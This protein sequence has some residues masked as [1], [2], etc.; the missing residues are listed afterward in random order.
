MANEDYSTDFLA[1]KQPTPQERLNALGELD[2]GKAKE[3]EQL[4][5]TVNLQQEQAG[6]TRPLPVTAEGLEDLADFQPEYETDWR[7]SYPAILASHTKDVVV[8]APLVG[9]IDFV[10]ETF[11]AAKD[12]AGWILPV[13]DYIQGVRNVAATGGAFAGDFVSRFE[14]GMAQSDR[15]SEVTNELMRANADEIKPELVNPM[16]IMEAGFIQFIEGYLPVAKGL[17]TANAASKYARVGKEAVASAIAA[18]FVLDPNDPNL[19][20]LIETSK[21]EGGM[22]DISGPITEFLSTDPRDPEPTNR[23]KN[24]LAEVATG[25]IAEAVF[26]ILKMGKASFAQRQMDKKIADLKP[27]DGPRIEPDKPVEA[28]DLAAQEADMRALGEEGNAM[29]DEVFGAADRPKDTGPDRMDA[30]VDDAIEIERAPLTQDSIREDFQGVINDDLREQLVEIVTPGNYLQT[31]MSL[32]NNSKF[33]L[34]QVETKEELLA[35]LGTIE[36]IM[37]ETMEKSGR[38]KVQTWEQTTQLARAVGMSAEQAHQLFADVAGGGGLAARMFASHQ[39]MVANGKR[40]L[41]LIK[42]AKETSNP[43]DIIEA[44]RAIELQAAI[45]MEVKGSQGEVARAMNAMKMQRSAT[46]ENFENLA[47]AAR[48][49]GVRSQYIDGLLKGG[50]GSLASI[51]AAAD[52]A[53][54]ATVSEMIA[55]VAINGLLTNP[56]THIVNMASNTTMLALTPWERLVASGI[57]KVRRIAGIGQVDTLSARAAGK[58]IKAMI[59]GL[60]DTFKLTYQALKD[61]APITDVRQRVEIAARPRISANSLG[62]DGK[63][64]MS[65]VVDNVVAPTIRVST[66]LLS[67]EDEFFKS[68]LYRGEIASVAY[69][70]ALKHADAKGLTGKARR[71]FVKKRE[72]FLVENPTVKMQRDAIDVARRGTFQEDA[73]S[74]I[75][76]LVEKVINVHPFVKLVVAPFYR[77]PTNVLRQTFIDRVPVLN[78]LM[79]KN[80]DAIKAGGPEGDLALAR[81]T[82]G[83]A[84]LVTGFQL[85]NSFSGPD[86]YIEIIGK[87][88]YESSGRFDKVKDYSIRIGDTWYRYNRF[89]PIGSWLGFASDFHSISESRYDPADPEADK[90]AMDFFAA[91]TGAVMSNALNKVWL[92]SL[93]DIVET[94][95]RLEKSSSASGGRAVEKFAGDQ[96]LK[97]VPFS[98]GLRAVTKQTDPIAREAWTVGDRIMAILPGASDGLS[99]RRDEL[100][101]VV[102]NDQGWKYLVSPFAATPESDNPLDQELARLDFDWP[103]T[104]KSLLN[105]KIPLDAEQYSEYK[106]LIGQEAPYPGMPHLEAALGTLIES[107]QYQSATDTIRI[108][109]VQS[110]RSMYAQIAQE[111]LKDKYPALREPSNANCVNDNEETAG[112]R[113][114]WLRQMLDVAAPLR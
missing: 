50:D 89:D 59:V 31:E 28:A 2:A 3:V 68:S 34:G 30:K 103:R 111:K 62:M 67:A 46:A 21:G 1:Q 92:K 58:N 54:R 87:K 65:R 44:N 15:A 41:A 33:D 71:A 26:G 25:P 94:L 102:E 91:G 40:M 70:T 106:R 60:G 13:D 19:A 93:S 80:R 51:N 101:R 96:L 7:D 114:D 42:V 90:S 49:F 35:V 39:T 74:K 55:E 100:G 38:V 64:V 110:Y 86:G 66:R 24:A 63:S 83:T 105:G 23:L 97:L 4:R 98:S 29:A 81:V 22:P 88:P 18:A 32:F 73:S 53:S 69:E 12:L 61:G 36:D 85:V 16:A 57:G 5:A 108:E 20:N 8:D 10:N 9:T 6:A 45:M 113:L 52:K 107:H 43:K 72:V 11:I 112:R 48:E 99:P 78:L 14:E 27:V 76:P 17:Q 75:G 84:A 109:L 47:S 82:T 37:K 95:N 77:T 56:T 104:D 79:K